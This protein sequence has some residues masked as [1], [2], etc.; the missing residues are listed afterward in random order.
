ML[1]FLTSGESH[2]PFLLAVLD[3]VP[4]GLDLDAAAVDRDLARR[5]RGHGRGDRMKI[6]K[7]AVR[8]VGGVRHGRTTGAPVALEI[9][10][11]DHA[12]W[13]DRM[14]PA[15]PVA[16]APEVTRPR[17]GHADLAGALKYGLADVRDVLER[18]SARETAARVA[19]GAVAKRLLAEIGASVVSHVVEIGGI[20]A[21][22]G[23]LAGLPLDET[24]RRAEDDPCACADP[25]ASTRMRAA[26]D[27]ARDAGDTL[28]GV[29]EAAAFGLPIGLG[30][31]AQHDRRLDG[32]L[33]AAVAS[34]P[35]VKGVEFGLGFEA[36][37][38][39]GSEVH[40]AIER[41]AGGAPPFARP[42][43]RAGG[44]E[45]GVTNGE[46]L[47]I[48]AAM[49]PISTLKKPL[50]SVDLRTGAAAEAA[51]E[52]SDVCAVPACAV[53][54]EAV[55]ALVL[56]AAALEKFGGDSVE[57]FRRNHAAYVAAIAAR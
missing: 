56:A 24:S 51:F 10:N 55:V 13:G 35:A 44:L 28:G 8:F 15:G 16:S 27:A 25:G 38:R 46:P 57:E 34:I 6:E 12:A 22:A 14:S 42:T 19:A 47:V 40:D 23:L 7:D 18:A 50:A 17:P 30:S 3:G 31:Y 49:K 36:A 48:R 52:R 5:Q 53:V 9:P 43:N 37:R 41:R 39:R 26:I 11:R 45:G 32:R 20:R 2:G 21:D 4:A 54:V 33:A 29:V 1:R